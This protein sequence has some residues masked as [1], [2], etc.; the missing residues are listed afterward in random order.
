MKKLLILIAILFTMIPIFAE[1]DLSLEHRINQLRRDFS[2][3]REIYILE[4][5]KLLPEYDEPDETGEIHLAILKSFLNPSKEKEIIRSYCL[6]ALDAE[7]DDFSKILIK[8][9]LSRTYISNQNGRTFPQYGCEYTEEEQEKRRTAAKLA[10]E[11]YNLIVKQ[12]LPDSVLVLPIP[13]MN[14]TINFYEVVKGDSVQTIINKEEADN[15][16]KQYHERYQQQM[17]LVKQTEKKNE[18]IRIKNGDERFSDSGIGLERILANM[19][20]FKPYNR[21]EMIDLIVTE[22]GDT[23]LAEKAMGL[24]NKN[25]EEQEAKWKVRE[26]IYNKMKN[27]DSI[28]SDFINFN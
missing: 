9:K 15:H 25:I 28:K 14:S 6:K 19:Y 24:L 5:E 21:K 22:I 16:S 4:L 18:L 13:D 26:D 20:Q 7:L 27:H 23:L 10:L 3:T 17:E 1:N 2:N 12:D 8:L 11:A